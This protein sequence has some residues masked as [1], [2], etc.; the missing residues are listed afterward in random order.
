MKSKMRVLKKAVAVLLAA[1]LVFP[2]ASLT[3]FAVGSTFTVT[4][5]ELM[6]INYDSL[7]DEEIDIILSDYVDADSYTYTVMSEDAASVTV[8]AASGKITAGAV[9]VDGRT[10]IPVS[11]VAVYEGGSEDVELVKRASEDVYDGVVSYD[12]N[13]FTVE[14]SYTTKIA[15]DA[16]KQ[17]KLLNGPYY[18][19]AAYNNLETIEA[20]KSLY[21]KL[22][23]H[24]NYLK[25]LIDGGLQNT[26]LITKQSVLDAI[27]ALLEMISEKD[28]NVYIEYL[29]CHD[30]AANEDENSDYDYSDAKSKVRYLFTNGAIK[31]EA[32]AIY[33]YA[34]TIY[35]DD[36]V[37]SALESSKNTKVKN[38]VN[39][40]I[41]TDFADLI[42]QTA[43]LATDDWAILDSAK[44]PLKSDLTLED[45]QALD[46]LALLAGD[47][48]YHDDEIKAE[49]SVEPVVISK[50][51][52]RHDVTVN[53]DAEIISNSTVDSDTATALATHSIAF[54]VADGASG[55]AVLSAITESGIENAALADWKCVN[56]GKYER[57]VDTIPGTLTDDLIYNI[58]YAPKAYS[59]AYNI[60]TDLPVSVP[61]GYNM[62]LPK[63]D[64]NN[65]VY[66]YYTSDGTHYFQN[67]IITITDNT[68]ITV[69]ESKPWTTLNKAKITAEVYADVLNEDEAAVLRSAAVNSDDVYIR[70]P[71]SNDDIVLVTPGGANSYTVAAQDYASGITGLTWTPVKGN[72]IKNDAVV[73]TFDI[74]N[75]SGTFTCADFDSVKV[76]YALDVSGILI[77]KAEALAALNVPKTLADE[78]KDQLDNIAVLTD[79]Y[80]NLGEFG[81]TTLQKIKVGVK[82]SDMSQEAVDAVMDM[83]DYCV[84]P[85]TNN[86]YIYEYLTDYLSD[87]LAYYYRDGNYKNMDEQVK[88]F[89]SNISTI[90]ND[91]GFIPLLET[92]E[93]YEEYYDKITTVVND[94]S[95]IELNGPNALIDTTSS[96]L[97]SLVESITDLIDNTHAFNTADRD[98]IITADVVVGMAEI[99]DNPAVFVSLS[100]SDRMAINFKVPKAQFKNGTLSDPHIEVDFNNEH[101]DLGDP[102]E[103][104]KYYV[105]SLTDISPDLVDKTATATLKAT[106][107]G[108]EYSKEVSYSVAQYCDTQCS[109]S[110]TGNT[111]LKNLC[112]QMLAY[113]EAAQNYVNG[114]S[115]VDLQAYEGSVSYVAPTPDTGYVV[116]ENRFT[117][118]IAAPDVKWKGVGLRL[119]DSIS[120]RV[121]FEASSIEGLT[122]NYKVGDGKIQTVAAS[123]FVSAGDNVYTAYLDGINPAQ[124]REKIEVTVMNGTQAVS[125]TL[126][127]SIATYVANMNSNPDSAESLKALVRAIMSYGDAAA[128]YVA[129]PQG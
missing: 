12:G 112:Y 79:L 108:N 42:D 36:N 109:D 87:E 16:D 1:I 34:Y 51:V 45:Y 74:T 129:D 89:N 28:R 13:D 26:V 60:D 75:G 29:L 82:G 85:D 68:D 119:E 57:T 30:P 4:D 53:V 27:N 92:L 123:D 50:I 46:D 81:E 97:S 103:S 102:V 49:L 55:S 96:S 44:N 38:A 69:V 56:T 80:D 32:I 114:T 101:Y 23:T 98:L 107:D 70:T 8:D 31:D 111:N 118:E 113:G 72:V 64:G 22:Y 104:G 126:N 117:G 128:A 73:L 54:K 2:A 86:L 48:E 127:Y 71:D 10:W 14:V 35:N 91:E 94:L 90:Y 63:H 106:K 5:G 122:I 3:T 25:N 15:V 24:R 58:S 39:K 43:D 47:A 121:R 17:A 83:L 7:T 115:T 61:Y 6:A 59:V 76:N 105:F 20:K 100:L 116:S 67:D 62:T 40:T 84:N 65:L 52:K 33:N 78:A 88:L 93:I 95:S 125:K 18:L 11:A 37:S 9:V 41:M 21:H 120:V 124:M 99:T 77:S 66:D 19:A 110:T